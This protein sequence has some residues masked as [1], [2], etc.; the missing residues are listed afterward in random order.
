MKPVILGEAPSRTGDAFRPLHGAP[1]IRLAEF[2]GLRPKE[3]AGIDDWYAA[4]SRSFDPWNLL[5]A[6][7]G[8]AGEGHGAAFPLDQATKRWER[9]SHLLA[10][11]V[12]V[13]LGA[14]LAGL[15]LGNT[16]VRRP[17]VWA[18]RWQVLP[19]EGGPAAVAA[20]PHPSGLNRV[21]NDEGERRRA[22][23]VLR[24]ALDLAKVG[25]AA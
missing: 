7:P 17:E 25:R 3:P 22:G 23:R 13:L 10:G 12:V 14:R 11:R 15:V 4:L 8:P 9:V 20:I 19:L 21:Y 16:R 24:E 18:Y 5:P 1:A 6:Y 2:A